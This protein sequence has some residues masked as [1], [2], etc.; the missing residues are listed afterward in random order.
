MRRLVFFILFV[1]TVSANAQIMDRRIERRLIFLKKNVE[2]LYRK[3][4][5]KEIELAKQH[6]QAY[7]ADKAG[8]VQDLMWALLNSRDFLLVH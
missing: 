3:P 6:L 4:T 1:L 8:A 2:P 5:A 7:A